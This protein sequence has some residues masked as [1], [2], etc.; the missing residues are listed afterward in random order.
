MA[1]GTGSAKLLRGFGSQVRQGLNI[2]VNVGDNFTWYGL[3]VCPDVDITMYAMAKMQNERR[4]WGIHADRF[5]FMDQ[6]AR[7]REDT[8]FKL[9]DRDLATNVLRTS[10]LNSG[11]S[12]TQVTKRLCDAL[13]IR[14]RLL[15]SCDEALE[16][17]VKTD[18]GDI[19][20]Q[21]FWVARGGNDR[22]LGISYR[23][24]EGANPGEG[25]LDALSTS[26][27]IVICPANPVS[28]IGPIL[29]VRE[30]R[31]ALQ[32]SKAIRIAVSPII[33]GAPVSGPAAAFM[34][35]CGQEVS[36]LGVARAYQ[37]FL[38]YLVIDT[39]DKSTVNDIR[40]L[41]ITPLV[42]NI[43]M[44]TAA[45]EAAMALYLMRQIRLS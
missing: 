26:R 12:L 25:V 1:G 36:V 40:A 24:L 27:A 8:W 7:Y 16:T 11:L 19:H 9:G 41:G 28:S 32:E 35:A 21:E 17:W 6:L 5:D 2:V 10:W 13:G 43:K 20:L 15:P 29:A 30:T 3:R 37:D 45:D 14:H 22:V 34:K 18:R 42:R 23:G 31:L 39:S 38:D 44:N 33:G 4:G